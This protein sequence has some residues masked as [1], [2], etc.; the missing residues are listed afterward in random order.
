MSI[1][2]GTHTSFI[3]WS[4][5]CET[6]ESTYIIGIQNLL[7]TFLFVFPSKFV[8]EFD[9]VFIL[10]F[11]NII[12]FYSLISPTATFDS[13]CLTYFFWILWFELLL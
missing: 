10:V 1:I 12:P 7:F 6:I 8:T 2:Q 13:K 11:G 9:A 4:L 3:I 5:V